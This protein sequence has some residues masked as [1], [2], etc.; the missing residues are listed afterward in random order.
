V[1]GWAPVWAATSAGAMAKF[2]ILSGIEALTI[3]PD[4]DTNGT[5]MRAAVE[6]AERWTAAGREVFVR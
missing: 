5:G 6:C 3:F 2:P 4:N 1:Q